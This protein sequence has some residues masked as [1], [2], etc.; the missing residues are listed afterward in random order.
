[1]D[2]TRVQC[3]RNAIAAFYDELE[4]VIEGIPAEFVYNVDESRCSHW[5]ERSGAIA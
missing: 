1:M 5:G 4:V 2:Y 3:D